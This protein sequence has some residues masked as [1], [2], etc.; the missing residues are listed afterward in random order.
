MVFLFHDDRKE[1]LSDL[2]SWVKAGEF[3]KGERQRQGTETISESLIEALC[4]E[5]EKANKIRAKAI[6]MQVKPHL[7]FKVI[8]RLMF[9]LLSILFLF[10]VQ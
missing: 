3:S 9:F 6:K 1:R 5:T 8:D 4:D 7:L 10:Y 2:V